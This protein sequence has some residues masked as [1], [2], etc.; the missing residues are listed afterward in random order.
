MDRFNYYSRQRVHTCCPRRQSDEVA[1]QDG[2]AYTV[3]DMASMLNSGMPISSQNMQLQA[4]QGS[5][6]PSWDVP[7]EYRRGVDVS[8]IWEAQQDSR[9][10]VAKYYDSKKKSKSQPQ[11]E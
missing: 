10:R 7:L 6:N 5:N 3:S 8:E 4:T 1:P 9:H 2:L 11:T